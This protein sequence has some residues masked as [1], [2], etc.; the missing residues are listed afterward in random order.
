VTGSFEV[1]VD[2][3]PAVPLVTHVPH[4]GTRIPPDVRRG[5]LVDDERLEAELLALT[6][7]HTAQLFGPPTLEAG[8]V[9]IVNR[10]SRLVVD[11]ERL[12]D[13]REPMARFG[14]GTVYSSTID[15]ATLRRASDIAGRVALLDRYLQPWTDAVD[16]LVGAALER[17]GRCLVLDGHS[18]PSRPLP[19]EDPGLARPDI[20]LG[21]AEPHVPEAVVEALTEACR[22]WGWSA[23]HNEPF[24][25]S[26]V[27]LPRFGLDRR[28]TS[29]MVEV[30]RGRYLDEAT[31][32]RG[33]GFAETAAL[34]R[35]LVGLAAAEA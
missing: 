7:W 4:G 16:R 24:A 13:A 8:G 9:A 33:P 32:E 31:G 26:Y 15:G 1:L 14:L 27:P 34:V 6:D 22:R 35:D 21:F 3:E 17:H 11:P 10:V 2:G 20:C 19:Y 12:P 25:G 5:L 29:I 28:V 23:A 30:N 18:F